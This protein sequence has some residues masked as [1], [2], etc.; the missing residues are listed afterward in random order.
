MILH[1]S[2][3]GTA[4]SRIHR[5]FLDVL[6]LDVGVDT[7]VVEGELLDSLGFVQLLVELEKEFGIEVDI[8]ELELED[9]GSVGRIARYVE[10]RS[11]P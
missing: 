5:I 8:A 2:G 7:E 1:E 9:F 11:T 6:Q 4:E 3:N 10:A